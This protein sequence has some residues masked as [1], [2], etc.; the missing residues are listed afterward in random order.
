MLKSQIFSRR[1]N[2]P[3]D[4][5]PDVDAKSPSVQVRRLSALLDQDPPQADDITDCTEAIDAYLEFSYRKIHT[6]T[7]HYE[8]LEILDNDP[9][10]IFWT[11]KI[12]EI[13]AA[14]HAASRKR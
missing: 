2:A 3:V 4:F 8:Y 14:A 5:R 6:N 9:A 10:H 11:I 13:D 12:H 7:S 1:P